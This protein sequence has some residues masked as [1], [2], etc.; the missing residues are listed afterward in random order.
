MF[1]TWGSSLN[2]LLEHQKLNHN[3]KLGVWEKININFSS[4]NLQM[5]AAQGPL[6]NKY[7]NISSYDQQQRYTDTNSNLLLHNPHP[8]INRYFFR[9]NFLLQVVFCLLYKKSLRN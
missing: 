4:K 1:L 5:T 8:L 2:C 7:V 6:K 9:Q 3:C